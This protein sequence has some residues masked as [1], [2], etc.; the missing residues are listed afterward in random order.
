MNR[1]LPSLL[2]VLVIGVIYLEGGVDFVEHRLM[3]LRFQT[4]ASRPTGKVVV[5]SADDRSLEALSSWPWPRGY[6]ATVLRNLVDAGAREVGFDVDF[7]AP[8][9]VQQ[10]D[11]FHAALKEAEGRTVLPVSEVWRQGWVE[12]RPLER[13]TGHAVLASVSLR[14]ES[15]GLVR[16]YAQETPFEGPSMARAMMGLARPGDSFHI[17]FGIDA[18]SITQIPFVD[19]LT[20]KFDPERVRHRAVLVGPTAAQLGGQMAVPVQGAMPGTLIE[21]LALES[22]AGGR[23]LQRLPPAVALLGALL[24]A[25]FLGPRLDA[26]SWRWGLALVSLS[27]VALFGLSVLVQATAPVILDISPMVMTLAGAYG[28]ELVRRIDHQHLGLLSQAAEVRRA[29]TMM[30]HVVEHSSEA[31]ITVDSS[32]R[33]ETFNPAAEELF[34]F[35]PASVVG[36]PLSDLVAGGL[37]AAEVRDGSGRLETRP[38]EGVGYRRDGST[39]DLEMAATSFSLEQRRLRVAF[40]RDITERKKQKIALEHQAT[41]DVLTQLPNRLLL[42][43]RAAAMLKQAEDEDSPAVV[44]VLDLDRFKEVNDTLGHKVGDQ[45]LQQIA[46]RLEEPLRPDDTIA[47]VG[48]DEFAVLLPQAGLEPARAMARLL[49]TALSKPFDLDGLALQVDVSIGIALYPDHGTDAASLLQH[50]DVAMY[51]AKKT[52]SP[53]ALYNPEK[54]LTSVRHLALRGELQKAVE[55]DHLVLHFQPKILSKSNQVFGME[56]LVRWNHPEHGL[57]FPDEFI[58]LA[59]NTGLIKPITRWVLRAAAAQ[60]SEWHRRGLEIPLSVNCSARNLMED[61]LPHAI[62]SILRKHGVP[63]RQVTL[64]ITETSLIEDPDRALQVATYLHSQGLS[65]SIDDFG[66]GYSSLDYLRKLP[67]QELKI[68][69][70]FVMKLDQSRGDEKIVLSIID[71]AHNLG[72]KAVAE[73]VENAT[74]WERIREMGCDVGQGYFFARPMAVEAL[75]EWLRTSTWSVSH[76]VASARGGAGS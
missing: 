31:I 32:G 67:V 38:V 74:V 55:Q 2:A 70:S 40:V 20:G 73:G 59:E 27:A 1:R 14:P 69:K 35:V 52:R 36:R 29:G 50:G 30:R 65:I 51:A 6:H 15:D 41:H 62:D 18:A 68:D 9:A 13:F 39:F 22:L 3:D 25:M 7:S 63:P 45:L 43:E 49:V 42:Q 17:D 58:P 37:A 26:A 53:V 11:A 23:A 71:L 61:D 64:E 72:L 34:Q 46:R 21:A 19:V 8:V 57:L 66:T 33:I 56:V 4:L 12:R 24:L 5:V 76:R 28:F 60:Y 75:D 54:D 16:Q 48:G 44:L 10:D 47:R